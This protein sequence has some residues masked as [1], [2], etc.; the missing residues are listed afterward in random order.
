MSASMCARYFSNARLPDA[1]RRYSVRGSRPSND[2]S[3]TMYSA[4][5]SFRAWTLRLPSVVSSSRFRSLNVSRSFTAS[6][7]TMPSRS[8]SWIKRSR[9][10]TRGSGLVPRGSLLMT[11]DCRP[12]TTDCRLPTADCRLPTADCR[13][14]TD[15]PAIAPRNHDTEADVKAAESRGHEDV[16]PG[17][18][19]D[20]RRDGQRHERDAHQRHDAHRQRSTGRERG[21][22]EQ[23]PAARE[24]GRHAVDGEHGRQHGAGGNRRQVCEREAL[25]RR[26]VE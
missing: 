9:P 21:A 17:R 12:L 15:L 1:V 4:S 10:R 23:E 26:A 20:K 11:R 8:R 16:P 24:P 13:L 3:T 2:F 22:I 6:A 14:L 7:E 18:P 5:S 25:H 19:C